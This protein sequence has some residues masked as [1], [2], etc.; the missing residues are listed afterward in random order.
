MLYCICTNV[1][2]SKSFCSS[3]LGSIAGFEVQ[4]ANKVGTEWVQ[5]GLRIGTELVKN[6]Y[7]SIIFQFCDVL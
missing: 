7:F 3:D 6:W 1:N 4:N 2:L 5:N